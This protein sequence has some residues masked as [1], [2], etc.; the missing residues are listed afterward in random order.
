MIHICHLI[1]VRRQR[2]ATPGASI[3]RSSA[4]GLADAI[5]APPCRTMI[6]TVNGRSYRFK[7][8]F[9]E[10]ARCANGP[11]LYNYKNVSIKVRCHYEPVNALNLWRIL[12]GSIGSMTL[13]KN[14]I[15]T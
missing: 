7:F 10:M 8:N 3:T 12:N 4:F 1:F 11:I 6:Y 5:C 14:T 15:I 9:H 13:L 2:W